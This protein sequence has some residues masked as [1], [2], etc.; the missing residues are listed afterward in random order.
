[1]DLLTEFFRRLSTLFNGRRLHSDLDEEMRLHIEL[2][3]QQHAAS[4]LPADE[5]RRVAHLS[6]GNPTLV[7]EQSHLAWGWGWLETLLQDVRFALRQLWKSPGFTITAVLTLA[8]GIGANTAIFT[9]VHA[10]LLKDLPVADPKSLVRVGNYQDCCILNEI[11][12]SRNDSYSIFPYET[13]KYLR[14]HTPEFEQLAAMQGGLADLSARRAS[15]DG[16]SHSSFGEFVSGN[17]FDTFGVKPFA[18]RALTPADDDTGAAPVAMLSYQAWQRDYAGDPSII[19]SSFFMN[20]H[21]I[22][23]VGVT[24]P[25]F[26][27]DRLS[28]NPPDF[29]LPISQEPTLGFYSA[30][31]KPQLGWLFLV[32]R[33]KPGVAMGSLQQKM[34]GLLRQSLG[35][36]EDFQTVRGKQL[37]A[38]AHVVLTP[39][40]Q[41]VVNL[42]Q[43]VASSLYLLLGLAG[44]V[45]L[46]ACAN[47]ANL[48]LVRGLARRAEISIRM[49][50]GAARARVVRQMLTE[51]LV[52]AS[53]GG[54]S[55]LLLAY[56]GARL[57]LG[58]MFSSAA[59]VPVH[60]TPSLPVLGFALAVS[61]AT[62]LVFGVVPAW[63]GSNEQPANAM[64]GVNRST[65]DRSSLLQR[66]L[67]IL[68]AALSVVLLIGAGLLGKSLN[69][70]QHQ[71][72]GL[73]ADNRV[74][75]NLNPL[76]AGYKP[77]QL[78]G[79][80][81]QIE[82]KFHAMPGVQNV[83]LT[84]YTPLYGDIWSFFAYV[85]GHPAPQSRTRCGVLF[86]IAPVRNTSKRS[87]NGSCGDALLHPQ[88]LRNHP[89]S[90]WSIR[91]S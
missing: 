57:L 3:A 68:Q 4:G 16:V 42:Q 20:T 55:G 76:K 74:I 14:D 6:F 17:Y 51:S 22:T 89:A 39:G 36:L 66:S 75:V 18:G 13:Y 79:L 78:Q 44:L 19:G 46:I 43:R 28:E 65:R 23:I 27:G 72:M 81:Q 48:M 49:A 73:E 83:G 58:L 63:I 32:G 25:G 8:L 86:S 82:D 61:L 24:P 69:K 77:G 67:V 85:Q 26:Y 34:S 40:G 9:L 38:K 70:L 37:L 62:G 1:M 87:G 50:L 53:L 45:L 10:I 71:D 84:L 59:Q 88:I 15:G 29:Y 2:R 11:S 31:N 12:S 21:P 56:A 52:L 41:G 30:R 35:E 54:V 7:R 5:A 33:V 90:R 60:A 64:R 80:Y 47:I 91:R